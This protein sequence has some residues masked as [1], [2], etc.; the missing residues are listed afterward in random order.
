MDAGIWKHKITPERI[1]EFEKIFE[2][3]IRLSEETKHPEAEFL[4]SLAAMATGFI[5]A[6]YD[7]QKEEVFEGYIDLVRNLWSKRTILDDEYKH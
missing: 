1:K 4:F 5:Y 7:T 3:L 2:Q 6:T